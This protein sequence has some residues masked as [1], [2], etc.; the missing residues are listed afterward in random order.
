MEGREQPHA[1]GYKEITNDK[2]RRQLHA[3]VAPSLGLGTLSVLNFLSHSGCKRA[4]SQARDGKIKPQTTVKEQQSNH[5][6]TSSY[7]KYF[8]SRMKREK[9][10]PNGLSRLKVATSISE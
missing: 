3:C 5:F 9:Y 7:P 10:E 6:K 2:P 4:N 1:D 8:S